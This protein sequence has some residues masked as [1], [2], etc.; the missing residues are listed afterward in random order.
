M[1]VCPRVCVLT[2]RA[3]S[4]AAVLAVPVPEQQCGVSG[5]RQHVAVPP[6]VGLRP[7]QTRHHVTV[8][9]HDLGQLTWTH[10]KTNTL[11]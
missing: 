1:C 11:Q 8:T 10:T 4:D 5:A 3:L 9:K 7:G 6:D 2:A